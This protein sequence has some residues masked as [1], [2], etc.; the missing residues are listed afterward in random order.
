MRKSR[1]KAPHIVASQKMQR[2]FRTIQ[3]IFKDLLFITRDALIL[4]GTY[5]KPKR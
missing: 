3:P 1:K 5:F 4:P 2:V